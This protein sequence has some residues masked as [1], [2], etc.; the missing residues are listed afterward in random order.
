MYQ[1]DP[2]GTRFAIVRTCKMGLI[3]NPVAGMGGAVGLHG[4]D[5]E[6]TQRQ[7]GALGAIPGAEARAIAALSLVQVEQLQWVVGPGSMGE[8]VAKVV[9]LRH[10]VLAVPIGR[11]TSSRDTEAC[12]VALANQGVDLLVFAGGDGTARDVAAAVGTAVP[13]LGIPAGVKMHSAVFGVTPRACAAVISSMLA[14]RYLA[15]EEREVVDLDEDARR[16]GHLTSAL[17]GHL[18]VPISPRT[19]QTRKLGSSVVSQG[20]AKDVAREVLGRIQPSCRYLLGPGTTTEAI[21]TLLGL[22]G[23]ILGVDLLQDG[24]LLGMDLTERE[25]LDEIDE[26]TFAVV[27]PVGGQGFLFGRGNQQISSA[28]LKRVGA[29]GIIVICPEQKLATLK[30]Q[31]LLVDTGDADLDM[32]LHGYLRV[33]TGW[34]KEVIYPVD[35]A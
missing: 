18:L 3:I 7:A 32:Q 30:G 5:G 22:Q 10:E 24:K 20:S 23:S 8:T 16:A 31:P 17:F 12:S 19:I 35:G 34:R 33:I 28:V 2:L 27:A 25:I 14:G 9:G 29:H 26:R 11:V 6:E 13:A 15:M 21:C 1:R 4:S